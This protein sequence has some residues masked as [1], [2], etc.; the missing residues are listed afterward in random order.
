[1]FNVK[2]NSEYIVETVGTSEGTQIKYKKGGYWYKLDNRGKEGLCEYLA[3]KFLSFTSL[4]KDE[5]IMYE[6]G[7]INDTPG[8]RS[9]DFIGK[10]HGEIITLYRMYRNEKGEDLAKYLARLDTMEDRIEYVI[11]FVK[12]ICNLDY[13]DYLR[14][15]FT[16]DAIILNE[17]R[18]VNN[19]AIMYDD[20][21]FHP[22]PIFDNGC[23][24]L[25]ANHS[26]KDN[27]SIAE[28]VKRVI[29][30]PFCGSFEKQFQYLGPGFSFNKEE[31]MRWLEEE[32][33]S[34]ERDVLMYQVK[35][36]KN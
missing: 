19:L 16:L 11:N 23:S 27:L 3:S 6:Q 15:I 26:V 29:A 25:T 1:M 21:G 33:Q 13:T 18:H 22:A 35:N 5:F 24:L 7:M 32:P 17:D 28:N 10:K 8:C 12:K 2:L 36:F 20:N 9:K 4:S 31:V 34:R 14:K 30:R